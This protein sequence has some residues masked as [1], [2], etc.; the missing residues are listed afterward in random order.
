ME[1]R[2]RDE[3]EAIAERRKLVLE[4][5]DLVVRE[6]ALPVERGR[7][8]IGEELAGELRVDGVGEL[9]RLLEVGGGRLEPE[10][11]A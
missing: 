1:A 8:V 11:S 7:A 9:A 6:G 3:L 4:R 10:R 2:E 5:G